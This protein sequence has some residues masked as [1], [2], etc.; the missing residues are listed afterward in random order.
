MVGVI[1]NHLEY[2]LLAADQN[3]LVQLV[4]CIKSVIAQVAG[5]P[6]TGDMIDLDLFAGSV[7]ARGVI[8]PPPNVQTEQLQSQLESHTSQLR[9]ALEN[10]V[11]RLPRIADVTTGVV[12][13]SG[14]SIT[15]DVA[16]S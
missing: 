10:G 12:T 11:Q 6:I 9:M 13:L 3:F 4:V 7:V 1:I 5:P 15:M 16:V 2:S 14:V 8:T